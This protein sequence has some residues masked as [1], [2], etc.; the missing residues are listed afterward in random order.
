[1]AVMLAKLTATG[2]EIRPAE[3][4]RSWPNCYLANGISIY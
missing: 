4:V 2:N 1:M 3:Q